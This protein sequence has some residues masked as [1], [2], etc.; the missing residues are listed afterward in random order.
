MAG[1]TYNFRENHCGADS[2]TDGKDCKAWVADG[3]V[4]V[5]PR[6]IDR[7]WDRRFSVPLSGLKE[8]VQHIGNVPKVTDP[9]VD[10]GT[11]QFSEAGPQKTRADFPDAPAKRGKAPK[12]ALSE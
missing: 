1:E 6:K 3:F 5:E 11:R 9:G 12:D 8:I 4:V 7:P 10:L 2:W